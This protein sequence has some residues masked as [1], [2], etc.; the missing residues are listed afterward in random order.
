MAEAQVEQETEEIDTSD[1]KPDEGRKPVDFENPEVEARFKRVYFSMKQNERISEKMA[2][3]NARLVERIEKMEADQ[4]E[5]SSSD[6]ISELKAA[7]KT[8]LEEGDYDK[9]STVRDQIT[10]IKVDA[11]APKP[12]EEPEEE[13]WLTPER[14]SYM[15]E[16]AG[17]KDESGTLLRPWA[18]PEHEDHQKMVKLAGDLVKKNPDIT[19]PTLLDHWEI[20]ARRSSP[21]KRTAASVLPGSSDVRPKSKEPSLSEDE[22]LIVRRMYPKLPPKDAEARYRKSKEKYL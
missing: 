13:D 1:L 9:V 14:E 21:P 6:R 4:A 19:L 2:T 17:Q 3:D 22:K 7:E 11:K 16:W 10:D 18:D 5:K 15:V 12:K 8:A 20:E